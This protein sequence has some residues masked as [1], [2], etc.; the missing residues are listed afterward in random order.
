MTPFAN[1]HP[2]SSIPTIFL[3]RIRHRLHG[4]GIRIRCGYLAVTVSALL[5]TTRK[6]VAGVDGE[7][8]GEDGA[9][10]DANNPLGPVGFGCRVAGDIVCQPAQGFGEVGEGVLR[11][12]D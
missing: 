8:D 11:N 12:R 9:D 6:T 4:C 3:T 1:L 2:T 7:A 5:L 10:D